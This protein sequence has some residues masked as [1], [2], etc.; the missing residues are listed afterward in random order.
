MEEGSVGISFTQLVDSVFGDP[1]IFLSFQ[2][3]IIFLNE[4]F[5]KSLKKATMIVVAMIL[6]TLNSGKG[7]S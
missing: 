3:T 6:D 7:F 5:F 1:K 4:L 2:Q